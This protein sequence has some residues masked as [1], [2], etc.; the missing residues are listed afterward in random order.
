[1]INEETKPHLRPF[2]IFLLLVLLFYFQLPSLSP[3]MNSFLIYPLLG[4]LAI[5]FFSTLS[6][7]LNECK[8]VRVITS[9]FLIV[10][11]MIIEYA[12]V[13]FNITK[14]TQGFS[15]TTIKFMLCAVVL[16]P[17]YGVTTIDQK[18]KIMIASIAENL[19]IMLYLS[20]QYARYGDEY[21]NIL[22]IGVTQYA[23]SHIFF[24]GAFFVF[25]LLASSRRDKRI[26]LVMIIASILFSL[27]VT[28]RGIVFFMT[29]ILIFALILFGRKNTRQHFIITLVI[30]ILA[31]VIMINYEAILMKFC[32][33]I[34]SERLTIRI[35]RMIVL[36]QSGE[37]EEAGGSFN[38]RYE[39]IKV[40]WDT[41]SSSFK[42]M[43]VGTGD[44][45]GNTIIG[46]HSQFVDIL[47]QYGI[48]GGTVIVFMIKS[49][50]K[51]LVYVSACSKS[52]IAKKCI[53]IIFLFYIIRGFIGTV[54]HSAIAVQM[55]CV[56][57]FLCSYVLNQNKQEV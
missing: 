38:G 32:D 45:Y 40:S 22:Q 25:Y 55:F 52:K 35:R 27:L 1:M 46:H 56:V 14:G 43:M 34:N 50:Y 12:Y 5:Y 16:I 6:L 7:Y 18:K 3:T 15:F 48:M 54:F 39:L 26:A 19:V 24:V 57:P 13:F 29:V 10:L 17:S 36:L 44:H 20:F 47:A 9:A 8:K 23:S 2:S 49:F 51:N 53:V 4:I 30:G 28:Q 11:F 41:F 21:A 42:N 37:M 33:I 31:V